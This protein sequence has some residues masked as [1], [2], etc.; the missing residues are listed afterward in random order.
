[1][2]IVIC[3]PG[4]FASAAKDAMPVIESSFKY[5]CS[6]NNVILPTCL[7]YFDP[8][9]FTSVKSSPVFHHLT[10]ISRSA[11]F[12]QFAP[13]HVSK[14]THMRG[15]SLPYKKLWCIC[16]ELLAPGVGQKLA[17]YPGLSHA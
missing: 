1:M 17:M 5:N 3:T 14:S 13:E 6:G 7:K 2:S 10:F 11:L 9:L 15:M 16:I 12:A 8:L 4:T